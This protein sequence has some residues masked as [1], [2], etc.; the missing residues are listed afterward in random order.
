[1]LMQI[2]MQNELVFDEDPLIS[3]LVQAEFRV[4]GLGLLLP[5]KVISN[6][7]NMDR[8]KVPY[9]PNTHSAVSRGISSKS[10]M[11]DS[12]LTLASLTRF[13]F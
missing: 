6:I 4:S 8:K 10:G 12:W 2:W 3:G 7:V 5:E 9:L 11:D 1:M 13:R